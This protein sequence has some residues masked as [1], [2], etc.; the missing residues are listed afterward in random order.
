MDKGI[1]SQRNPNPKGLSSLPYRRKAD[2]KGKTLIK[3]K[4]PQLL[5]KTF[6]KNLFKCLAYIQES[7]GN[8]PKLK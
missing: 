6:F 1:H 2:H 5:N 3:K 8:F 7:N 4:V